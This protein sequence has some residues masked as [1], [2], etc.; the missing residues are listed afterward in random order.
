MP[1]QY[2]SIIFDL[3]IS[4]D[5]AAIDDFFTVAFIINDFFNRSIITKAIEDEQFFIEEESPLKYSYKT[6]DFLHCIINNIWIVNWHVLNRVT[7]RTYNRWSCKY[8]VFLLEASNILRFFS[9]LQILWAYAPNLFRWT[10]KILK[11]KCRFWFVGLILLDSDNKTLI[12]REIL[13]IIWHRSMFNLGSGLICWNCYFSDSKIE[14][15]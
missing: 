11:N 1:L 8:S 12:W 7:K 5:V 6:F 15:I 3:W 4:D 2:A 13:D 10:K 14:H 9:E